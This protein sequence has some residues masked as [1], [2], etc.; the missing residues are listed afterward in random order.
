[1]REEKNKLKYI[2]DRMTKFHIYSIGIPK[3]EK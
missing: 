3:G 2:E 1:M